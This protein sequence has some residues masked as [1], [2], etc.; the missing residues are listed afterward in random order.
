MEKPTIRILDN[1]PLHI[2]GRVELVDASGS[3]YA[4]GDQLTLCR[5]GLSEKAPFCD[6]SHR[7][8]GFSSCCRVT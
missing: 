5:C 1:G 8:G 3:S 2:K 4:V 6:G 7:M